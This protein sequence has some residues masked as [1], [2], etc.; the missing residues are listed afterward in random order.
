MDH[1]V[2][3]KKILINSATLLISD[4]NLWDEVY[5]YLR[6]N[7]LNAD[8]YAY[9]EMHRLYSGCGVVGLRFRI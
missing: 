8:F 1:A 6:F 9:G 2:K 4:S 7:G 3:D 5:I